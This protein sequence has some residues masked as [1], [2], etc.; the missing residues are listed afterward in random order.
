MPPRPGWFVGAS[1]AGAPAPQGLNVGRGEAP[2][3]TQPPIPC[4]VERGRMPESKHPYAVEVA[5]DVAGSFNER[6]PW[7]GCCRLGKRRGPSTS[8]AG[9]RAS[10]PAALRMTGEEGGRFGA[11]GSRALNRAGMSQGVSMRELPG[12][13]VVGRAGQGFFVALPFDCAQGRLSLRSV[14]R[15]QNDR[16]GGMAGRGEWEG[17]SMRE[18]PGAVVVVSRNAG[19]LDFAGRLASEPAC[20]ARDDR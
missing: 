4:H 6:T 8:Q 5:N 15:P 10:R 12:A 9:S 11:A 3:P 19:S 18:L 2:S 7:S 17:V 16:V 13:I 14:A 1:R 20:C